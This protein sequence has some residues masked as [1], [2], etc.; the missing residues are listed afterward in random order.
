MR[1]RPAPAASH[2]PAHALFFQTSLSL[3]FKLSELCVHSHPIDSLRSALHAHRSAR[4]DASL[5]ALSAEARVACAAAFTLARATPASVADLAEA[6]RTASTADFRALIADCAPAIGKLTQRFPGRA[7]R[8]LK[9][10]S[11]SSVVGGIE[12]PDDDQHL[13]PSGPVQGPL[14]QFE[15]GVHL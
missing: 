5:S 13:A 7:S 2:H 9:A 1:R 3:P 12:Q 15:H 14:T 4:L 8:V 11:E 10:L 6:A